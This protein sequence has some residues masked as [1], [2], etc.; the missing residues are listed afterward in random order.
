M[1]RARR[2]PWVP[3]ALLAKTLVD[4]G[5]AVQLGREEWKDNHKLFA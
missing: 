4:A 2:N 5:T 1:G 3:V